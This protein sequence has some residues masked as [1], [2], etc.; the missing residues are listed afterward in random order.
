MLKKSIILSIVAILFLLSSTILFADKKSDLVTIIQQN[1]KMT[2]GEILLVE[3]KLELED[4]LGAVMSADIPILKRRDFVDLA[5]EKGLKP[6]VLLE[7]V[8]NRYWKYAGDTYSISLPESDQEYYIELAIRKGADISE[9]HFDPSKANLIE[10]DVEKMCEKEYGEKPC[11]P[12]SWWPF[13]LA[14]GGGAAAAQAVHY[15]IGHRQQNQQEPQQAGQQGAEM[16]PMLHASSQQPAS[17]QG[18]SSNPSSLNQRLIEQQTS[19]TVLPASSSQTTA[20]RPGQQQVAPGQQGS[21]QASIPRQRLIDQQT[22]ETVSPASSQATAQRPGQQQ[23]APGQ[24]GSSQA[25]IPEQR[26]IDQHISKTLLPASPSPKPMAQI[27]LVVPGSDGL[28]VP[29]FQ[30]GLDVSST[31]V[32]KEEENTTEL[33]QPPI[34]PLVGFPTTSSSAAPQIAEQNSTTTSKRGMILPG[35]LSPQRLIDREVRVPPYNEA[36]VERT[37]QEL[38][39][40]SR[41][42]S[43]STGKVPSGLVPAIPRGAIPVMLPVPPGTTLRFVP[44]SDRVA[45]PPTFGGERQGTVVR[46]LK[47]HEPVAVG[48]FTAARTD[49]NITL[50]YNTKDREAVEAHLREGKEGKKEETKKQETSP[51]SSSS[52]STASTTTEKPP[53]KPSEAKKE[54]LSPSSSS[55]VTG[56]PKKP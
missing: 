19:E 29:P 54:T 26:L 49:G 3:K 36:D 13:F 7:M 45:P 28:L 23:V 34:R 9:I 31:V 5:L 52:D 43:D 53:K 50:G 46:D 21:S 8:I 24:Q 38:H 15:Y 47:A 40:R 2:C 14:V 12:S 4:F 27:P 39:K 37:R 42:N 35:P 41:S 48:P 25:S 30:R 56:A 1:N 32:K 10:V 55:T 11:P 20:Q 18:V 33:L 16:Q 51:P 44:S 17:G 6:N 22:S